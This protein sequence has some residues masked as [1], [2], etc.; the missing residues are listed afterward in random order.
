MLDYNHHKLIITG[1]LGGNM[2]LRL[3]L[4]R[5][6]PSQERMLESVSSPTSVSV[7]VKQP[8]TFRKLDR[9]VGDLILFLL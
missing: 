6:S 2:S 8:L 5:A 3:S 7:T 4:K 1:F 9:K